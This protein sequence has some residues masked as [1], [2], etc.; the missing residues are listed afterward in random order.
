MTQSSS[1]SQQD[2][3]IPLLLGQTL[4]SDSS[5]QQGKIP[6]EAPVHSTHIYPFL[7]SATSG[8]TILVPEQLFKLPFFLPLTYL[9]GMHLGQGCLMLP[10]KPGCSC[11]WKPQVQMI[12]LQGKGRIPNLRFSRFA[13]HDREQNLEQQ[14]TL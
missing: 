4:K 1:L 8:Y 13:A 11:T 12:I 2:P 14:A 5:K 6:T 10:A 3:G 9:I 7:G